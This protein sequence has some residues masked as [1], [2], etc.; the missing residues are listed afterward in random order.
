LPEP[1]DIRGGNFS[2]QRLVSSGEPTGSHLFSSTRSSH[3]R[4]L[5]AGNAGAMSCAGGKVAGTG[6]GASGPRMKQQRSTRC[7][8]GAEAESPSRLRPATSRR[9]SHGDAMACTSTRPGKARGGASCSGTPTAASRYDAAS[10]AGRRHSPHGAVLSPFSSPVVA[11][12]AAIGRP[13]VGVRTEH[14]HPP[15][16]LFTDRQLHARRTWLARGR[17]H[18]PIKSRRTSPTGD[19]RQCERNSGQPGRQPATESQPAA[20][21]RPSPARR[22]SP[23]S[24]IRTASLPAKA[25][26]RSPGKVSQCAKRS[27]GRRLR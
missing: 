16:L 5:R 4:P 8:P 11:A 3:E 9:Q 13:L 17:G 23:T 10:R 19:E 25:P 1:L 2:W 21:P 6:P 26:A 14:D 20:G 12:I 18:A 7:L 24:R 22:T 15:V 27:S